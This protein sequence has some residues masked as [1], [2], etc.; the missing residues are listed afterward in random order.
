MIIYTGWRSFEEQR[1]GAA[2][3]GRIDARLRHGPTHDVTRRFEPG[4]WVTLLWDLG[5]DVAARCKKLFVL[6]DLL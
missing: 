4:Y 3:L 1:E 2:G 5:S 6:C